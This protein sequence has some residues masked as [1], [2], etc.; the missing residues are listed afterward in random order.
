[1][2]KMWSLGSSD[3]CER[4]SLWLFLNEGISSYK[5]ASKKQHLILDGEVFGV[6][7]MG[8]YVFECANLCYRIIQQVPPA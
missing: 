5:T 2:W 8:F 6:R 7:R 1:M 4:E 3:G